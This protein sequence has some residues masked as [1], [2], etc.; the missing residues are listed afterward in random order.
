MKEL[1]EALVPFIKDSENYPLTFLYED[2]EFLVVSGEDSGDRKYISIGVRWRKTR[3]EGENKPN[4]HGFPLSR[5]TKCWLIMQDSLALCLL[6]YIKDK[7]SS[8]K[9]EK[10]CNDIKAL[11]K[12]INEKKEKNEKIT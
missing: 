9:R 6:E 12:K 2:D 8:D 1:N 10:V 4:P 11:Q 3:N 7:V 5:N